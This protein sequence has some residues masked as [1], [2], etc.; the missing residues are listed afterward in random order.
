MKKRSIV[1][2]KAREFISRYPRTIIWRLKQ[3]CKV[4]ERHLNPGETVKYVFVAQK[5][6]G[7]A[8]IMSSYVIALTNKRIILGQKR[9]M[10]GYFLTVITPDMFNDLSVK[11]GMLWGE[12]ELDTIKETVKFKNIQVDALPEIETSITEY[13]MEEKKKLSANYTNKPIERTESEI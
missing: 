5:D 2:E 11:S 6:H 8:D 7:V 4:I 10:F 9:L 12:V 13:M 3:H 1:Y